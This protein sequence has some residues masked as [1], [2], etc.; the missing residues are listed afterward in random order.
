MRRGSWFFIA[1][2]LTIAGAVAAV[3]S[4]CS[5]STRTMAAPPE[6]PGATYAGN[7]ACYECHT[8]ITRVFSA[9]PHAHIHFES[10]K[11]QG[12]TG[13]ESCHGPGSKHIE[14]GGGRG[15]FIVNPGKDPTAC[16]QCHLETEAEFKLPQHHPVI[17]G[18]MNCVQCHDPHG[19]DIF[20]T[21]GGL[22]M[23]RR[24][25]SCAPCHREQ[26]RPFVFEHEALREGCAI[27]HNP[28]G[29]I[30]R[31]LLLEPDPNLC[32]KCHAQT[33][34]P[35]VAG[36]QIYIGHVDHTLLLRQGTCWAAGC[37]TAVHGSNVHPRMFY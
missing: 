13:C 25:E 28:H 34:G 20:K 7:K 4:S 23:A 27:C 37:H 29:S 2:L 12:Q 10:A 18:R 15:K 33:H 1:A 19:A 17:E 6:I 14:A 30:N 9:S 24:N 5:T 35:G 3:L 11:L 21:S 36:G 16:F 26:T 8:N 32:L 31:K 22:A